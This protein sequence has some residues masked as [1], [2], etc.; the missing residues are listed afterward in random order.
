M[1]NKI[2]AI[3]VIGLALL[4]D[5]EAMKPKKKYRRSKP[6]NKNK[7]KKPSEPENPCAKTDGETWSVQ[8]IVDWRNPPVDDQDACLTCVV[9]SY[10]ASGTP[11]GDSPTEIN[12]APDNQIGTTEAPGNCAQAIASFTTDCGATWPSDEGAVP[13][14][15][16][17]G[18]VCPQKWDFGF[19]NVCEGTPNENANPPQTPADWQQFGEKCIACAVQVLQIGTKKGNIPP[20]LDTLEIPAA[21]ASDGCELKDDDGNT[22]DA[23]TYIDAANAFGSCGSN[24]PVWLKFAENPD[25][26]EGFPLP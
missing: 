26:L 22:D 13:A 8:E 16:D 25:N 17:A 1:T 2:F 10:T 21:S 4:G 5:S 6:K 12:G 3:G 20:G 15:L 24:V 14:L 23:C 9:G 19:E 18:L 7:N 11:L